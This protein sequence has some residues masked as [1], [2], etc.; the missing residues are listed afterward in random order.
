MTSV[1]LLVAAVPT[2]ATEP[3]HRWSKG[4]SGTYSET[5]QSI[6]VDATGNVFVASAFN[7]SLWIDGDTLIAEESS[8]EFGNYNVLLSKFANNG[9]HLWSRQFGDTLDQWVREVVCD[10]AGNVCIAGDFKG[11]IDFGGG[12]LASLGTGEDL[13]VAAFDGDGNHLWS[14]RFGNGGGESMGGL[15]ADGAGN[16]LF[17][18]RGNGA[19]DFGG[20]PLVGA[21][22]EVF[23]VKLDA[24]GNHVWSRGYPGLASLRL[25]SLDVDASNNV[26]GS[27]WFTGSADFGGGVL[28][29]NGLIDALLVKWDANG[30]HVFSKRF[31]D[32][33][34]QWGHS[35]GYDAS[36][37]IVLSGEFSGSVDFG[38]GSIA[39]TGA[40]D[41][42]VTLFDDGG[43]HV[44]TRTFGG[45]GRQAA[46]EV[47]VDATGGPVVA[48]YYVAEIDFGDGAVDAPGNTYLAG[49]DASGAN[50]WQT[51]YGVGISDVAVGPNGSL[52]V[53][54]SY[55]GSAQ[56]GNWLLPAGN[57]NGFVVR[58]SDEPVSGMHDPHPGHG[59]ALGTNYPNPFNP[60]TTIQFTLAAPARAV[61]GIYDV[62]GRR[63]TRLEAGL[64]SAGPHAVHWNGR[65]AHGRPVG[66]GVYLYRLEG[67]PAAGARKMVLLK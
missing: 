62:K 15:A 13:F 31:G 12:P 58:F 19:L 46:L 41:A 35:V 44:W 3:A 9:D 17:C 5:C 45:N 38:G 42:F 61:V 60:S 40:A 23:L 11:V 14:R 25:V 30:N 51:F 32:A 56:F 10:A 4:F 50:D 65:D 64:L 48:G 29:A 52:D 47:A 49:L 37:N 39:S 66:S 18:G 21:P 22:W 2:H 1:V 7:D 34:E 59:A 53:C 26:V 57:S 67:M 36:G 63:V 33:S 24:N 27:G 28:N 20:G 55:H 8:D 16:V 6:A 43:N 54:G